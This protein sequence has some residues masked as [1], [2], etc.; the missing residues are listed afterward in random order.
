MYMLYLQDCGFCA[1]NVCLLLGEA[2]LE[3][4]TCFLARR[5]GGAGSCSLIGRVMSQ[6]CLEAALGSGNL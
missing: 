3:T 5:A 6:A 4:C 1:S 2:C